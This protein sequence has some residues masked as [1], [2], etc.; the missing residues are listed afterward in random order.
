MNDGNH[1]RVDSQASPAGSLV[2]RNPEA[3]TLVRVYRRALTEDT[4]RR[5]AR[6]VSH[7][8]RTQV[9]EAIASATALRRQAGQLR[10]RLR[11][12]SNPG[13]FKGAGRRAITAA[14]VPRVAFVVDGLSPLTAYRTN[15]A[16]VTD[17]LDAA[18]IDYFC[19]RGGNDLAPSV[20]IPESQRRS[21]LRALAALCRERPGY[22]AVMP[23][24]NTTPKHVEPTQRQ[25]A[26][27][28]I[29][30]VP[31]FRLTWF[32]ADPT[33]RLVMGP[34]HGCDIE[35][36][37]E[38]D[39]ELIAPRSNRS[40]V[41]LRVDGNPVDVPGDTFT[42]LVAQDSLGG[43]TVRSREEFAVPV[44]NDI[45]FPIDA[46]FTWVDGADEKWQ[47]RRAEYAG[48]LATESHEEAANDAR[49]LSRDELRYSLRALELNA[50]WIRTVYLV[51]DD[52][53]PDWLVSE[54]PR[55]RVVSHREIF[56]DAGLLP[57]FNSHAI[58]SQ[59]HHIEGLSEQFLYFNDDVFLASPLTPNA[60]FHSN[61]ISRFFPSP[62]LVPH[63]TPSHLDAPVAAAGKNNRR[64]IE[65]EFGTTLIAKMKHVPHALRRSV[66]AEIEEQFAEEY[67]RTAR[68][69]F[70]SPMDLSVASSLAHYY[71]YHT[72]RSVPGELLY[73]YIDLSHRTATRRLGRAIADRD[74]QVFCINDTVS[75]SAQAQAQTQLL[76]PFLEAYFPVASSFERC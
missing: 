49:Y 19:V 28:K 2:N 13:L 61:G 5:I 12:R 66:L 17:A 63:G 57:T 68:S 71:G 54:H 70:R 41:Q 36:W 47:L 34:E 10:T 26:W 65:A 43:A 14:G 21:A 55:L 11:I 52:Q 46:V 16:S 24:G 31:V 58:E 48:E 1:S 15:R 33:G 72:G 56:S 59:L 7:D 74:L 35:F 69:R 44:P 42:R 18:G 29:D 9:M 27:R 37:T 8:A 75:T 60:F 4:R 30:S 53:V 73:D 40:A 3:S 23:Q 67:Q 50:P 6:R 20:G 25:S 64:L 22:L 32:L 45:R 62:A 39:G 38:R 51:T 76:T